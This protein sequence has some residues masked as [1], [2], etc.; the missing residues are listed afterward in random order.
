MERNFGV[1]D[2][3]DDYDD[4]DDDDYD[5]DDGLLLFNAK[6]NADSQIFKSSNCVFYVDT[7]NIYSTACQKQW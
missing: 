1:D 7:D 6:E 2:D 3:Y 5:D 4:Y